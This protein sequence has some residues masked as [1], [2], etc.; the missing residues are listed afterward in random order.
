MQI[1]KENALK[2]ILYYCVALIS[3]FIFTLV[4]GTIILDSAKQSH[5]VLWVGMILML[6]FV[7]IA[8]QKCLKGLFACCFACM[9]VIQVFCGCFLMVKY[10]TWDVHSVTKSAIAI[11]N[12][13]QFNLGY[14]STCPNNIAITSIYA[15]LLKLTKWLFNSTSV[16]CLVGFNIIAVDVSILLAM[17]CMDLLES[18]ELK[19]KVG[20]MLTLFAPFYLYIPIC[21]TDTVSMPFV[22]G[23]VYL[24]LAVVKEKNE[25]GQ[26]WKRNLKTAAVGAL[27]ALGYKIKGSVIVL[28]VAAFLYWFFS[29]RFKTVLKAAIPFLFGV[30]MMLGVCNVVFSQL[31][32]VD[33]SALA[34]HKTP[35]THYFMMGLKGM[36]NFNS[37]DWHFTKNIEGYEEKKE[38]TTEELKRRID[39]LGVAGLIQKYHYKATKYTWNYGTCYAERYLGDLGDQPINKNV[40]HEFVLS[41]GMYHKLFWTVTQGIWC[42]YLLF[43]IIDYVF[44][45]RQKNPEVFF[46]RLCVI[47]LMLFL[48]IWETH[49]RYI[50]NFTPLLIMVAVWRMN[51][52]VKRCSEK[53]THYLELAIRYF[54]KK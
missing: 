6:A 4:A 26:D 40:L 7:I 9:I 3:C 46:F 15:I 27:I 54:R 38:A 49:P 52:V 8:R 53:G 22:L 35:M 34:K 13:T 36:G 21:Y 45:L 10:E 48:F 33:K 30:T 44:G 19:Y 43:A 28:V 39:E 20:I 42:T 16:Y 24:V 51:I 47:G 29:M 5:S 50:L 37:E 41:R 11:A 32:P 12:N 31:I 25:Q 17:K 18:G 23:I 1:E 2:R 14:F